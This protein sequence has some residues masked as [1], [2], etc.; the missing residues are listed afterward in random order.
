MEPK[1]LSAITQ[2]SLGDVAYEQIANAL[3]GGIFRPGDRLTIRQLA[4]KLNIS[5]TPTR[6]AVRRLLHEGALEQ[7]SLR[8]VRVP[9]IT[10]SRY[11]EIADIRM[12]LEGLA[13]AKAAAKCTEAGIKRL[14]ENMATNEEA[15]AS[16]DWVTA[17]SLN[18][19][20]HFALAEIA[21]AAVLRGLL[22]GLWLQIGPA[23]SS[24]YNK[25]GRSM[26]DH[27]YQV[28]DALERG[29]SVAARKAIADDIADSVDNIV[30]NLGQG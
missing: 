5:S 22:D 23:I 3:I 20:F 10:Q 12:E 7:W 1:G 15:I 26:I 25:G 8:D 30:R 14:K 18:K 9:V 16:G 11:R 13:A 6:D 24:F 2:S 4:D 29:D 17:I 28:V 19:Q 21:E 27:H